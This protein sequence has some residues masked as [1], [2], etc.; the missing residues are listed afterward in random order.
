M[1]NMIQPSCK[2]V[3]LEP[4]G[5]D[6]DFIDALLQYNETLNI[7]TCDL[8]TE[9]ISRLYDKYKFFDN[10]KVRHT[11]TLIDGKF[12]SYVNQNGYYD[13]IIGN[14]PY[15]AWQEYDH[16]K[17]LK[18]K[19][20]G[21][22]V[23]ETYTLFLL[24]CISL[25][26]ENGMLSFII[27]DT[28][29]FLHNHQKLR[30]FILTNTTI[31]E[32]LIFPSKFFPGVSFGYSNLSIITIQKTNNID[33][34]MHNEFI[35]Y[36]GFNKVEELE[37]LNSKDIKRIYLDQQQVYNTDYHT[38]LLDNEGLDNIIK[39]QSTCLRD[40][41]YCVTGIY[42]GDN[43]RFLYVNNQTEKGTKDY[44]HVDLNLID[45]NCNSLNG[46]TIP[47]KYIPLVKGNSTTKYR[48]LCNNWY[49]DWSPEA[50]SHYT[51]NKKA[52]F[53]NSSFYFK[54]GIA[55]PMVKSSK[56]T[57]TII[58]N[59]VFDQSIVG[60]FPKE[61][62]YFYFLLGLLNSDIFNRIIHVINPTAN[63]SANY[64]KK[65]PIPYPTTKQLENI[66]NKVQ[67]MIENP[68]DVETQNELNNLFNTLYL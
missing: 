32:I 5:G 56:I 49:I 55:L 20:N 6:G 18:K 40:F 47:Y 65:V 37:N 50:I 25:L 67:L 22:Y 16:R 51:N 3:I 27:P 44:S 63:N 28:Y 61:E 54:K 2:D 35:V 8:N 31:K 10:I 26:K 38:F 30:E 17:L 66:N 7:E 9:A 19:Y 13:K 52:R 46:V 11:D 24:R 1:V 42:T 60:I 57:A 64:L 15:G 39:N 14:P 36:R 45:L 62:K 41:A 4:C 68:S 23:K 48:R 43:K 34:A 33:K 59:M 29:L 21:F 12:D 58:N 53:Q